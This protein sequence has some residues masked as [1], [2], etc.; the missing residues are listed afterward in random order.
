VPPPRFDGLVG[1]GHAPV[2][3]RSS[4]RYADA[5]EACVHTL[6]VRGATL[7]G[8][9]A[10]PRT[11]RRNLRVSPADDALISEAAAAL[12]ESVSEFLVTSGRA[13]AEHV[14]ADRTRFALDHPA[15]EAFQAALDRPAEV[16]P[17]VAELLRRERPG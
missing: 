3:T 12:G 5:R 1:G 15:W 10:E 8:V 2:H 13:R 14:L 9:S 4:I 16:N 11:T 6:Y 7:T 17:A